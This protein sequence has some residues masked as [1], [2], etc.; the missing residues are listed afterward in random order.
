MLHELEVLPGVQVDD[1]GVLGRRGLAGDHVVPAFGGEK[2]E[3][4]VL[5]VNAYARVV[6]GVAPAGGND[7]PSHLQDVLREVHHVDRLELRGVGQ[8][9][10]RRTQ[11]VTDEEGPARGGMK[12]DRP[13]DV[14]LH[15]A[16][17][18]VARP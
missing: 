9:G 16:S 4:P 17:G 2:E 10:R 8:G 6:E 12:G 1:A 18:A 5:H 7:Q 13:V 14:G 3:P 15:V 11:P